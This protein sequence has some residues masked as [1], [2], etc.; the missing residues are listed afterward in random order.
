MDEL[1]SIVKVI[2]FTSFNETGFIVIYYIQY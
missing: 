2:L 1:L